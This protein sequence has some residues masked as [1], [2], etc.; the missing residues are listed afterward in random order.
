MLDRG[1][2]Q[3]DEDKGCRKLYRNGD[4]AMAMVREF[5]E[6]VEELDHS[7]LVKEAARYAEEMG[8]QLE[9]DY[10]NL[11]FIKHDGG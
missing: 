7:S 3:S 8:L 6:R 2:V 4:P 11:T 1:G 5:E 9:L 10:P